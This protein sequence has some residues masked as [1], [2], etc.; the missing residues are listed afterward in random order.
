MRVRSGRGRGGAGSERPHHARAAGGLARG[1]PGIWLVPAAAALLGAMAWFGLRDLVGP[2]FAAHAAL[3]LAAWGVLLPAGAVVARYGKVTRRQD[4]PRAVDNPWWWNWHRGLQYG[5]VALATLAFVLMLAQ[6]GA[7]F[8]TGHGWLGLAVLSLGW[9]QVLAGWLRGTKGGPT[10]DGADPSDLATWRGDH[11]DMT[12]RRR[13]FEIWHKP[14]GWLTLAAAA[15]TI[16]LGL[17]LVGAPSWLLVLVGGVQGVVVASLLDGAARGR[18]VDTHVALW[19][20][21]NPPEAAAPR[22]TDCLRDA[23]E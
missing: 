3:M 13:M 22:D 23:A 21:P 16:L 8:D 19:G 7:R 18:W 1:T 20:P 2:V 9:G 12:R 11:Y 4:F 5:G 15:V 10:E 17:D 6:T 14:A